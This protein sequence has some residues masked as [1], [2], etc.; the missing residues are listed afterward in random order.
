MI[1]I[2]FGTVFSW[3]NN[4]NN[5]Y[6]YI[7]IYIYINKKLLPVLKGSIHV[8]F[9]FMKSLWKSKQKKKDWIF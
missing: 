1:S 7:Y 3:V 8:K 9:Y 4:G 5:E 6:I 2:K